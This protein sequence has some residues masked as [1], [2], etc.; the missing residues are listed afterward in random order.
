MQIKPKIDEDLL[1]YC[2]IDVK[3]TMEM[4]K[5][6]PKTPRYKEFGE[7]EH[8]SE[9]SEVIPDKYAYGGSRKGRIVNVIDPNDIN[10]IK[11]IT[12]ETE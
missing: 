7:S 8:H 3:A 10:L 11:R 1:E 2:T 5:N 6:A 4:F 12:G 9:K